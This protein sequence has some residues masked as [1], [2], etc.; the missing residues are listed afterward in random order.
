MTKKIRVIFFQ[1]GESWL[2]QGLEHDICVQA[3]TV[4]DL[5]GRFEVAVRLEKDSN[6]R[7]DHIDK[8]PSHFFEAWEKRSADVNPKPA[9]VTT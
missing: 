5:F 3:P 6:G 7:L 8:A 2:A 4:E 1:E 9:E